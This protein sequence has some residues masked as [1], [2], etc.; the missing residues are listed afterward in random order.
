MLNYVQNPSGDK[1]ALLV[2]DKNN[3]M[4]SNS[5]IKNILEE[6]GHIFLS[7]FLKGGNKVDFTIPVSHTPKLGYTTFDTRTYNS[8]G[9]GGAMYER[10]LGN[11]VIEILLK[12]GRK[13][14]TKA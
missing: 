3:R 7:C 1:R 5:E 12:D 4:Y 2:D 6:G 10:H 13:L 9:I 11:E 8:P 14:Q